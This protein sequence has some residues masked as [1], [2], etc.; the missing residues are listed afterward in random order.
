MTPVME[1]L[2][3]PPSDA[4]VKREAEGAEPQPDGTGE[5][6]ARGDRG[7]GRGRQGDE[8]TET[9]AGQGD[10]DEVAQQTSSQR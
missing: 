7:R 6:P 4:P 2:V 1:E 5:T 10:P 8:T 3:R 9:Q